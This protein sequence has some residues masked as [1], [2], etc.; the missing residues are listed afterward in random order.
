MKFMIE[1][2]CC[3]VPSVCMKVCVCVRVGFAVINRNLNE[4]NNFSWCVHKFKTQ[5]FSQKAQRKSVGSFHT[6]EAR[7]RTESVVYR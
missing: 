5:P 1:I 6:S 7:M 3:E 4:N 2:S